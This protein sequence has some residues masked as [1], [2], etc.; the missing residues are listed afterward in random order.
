MAYLGFPKKVLPLPV[1]HKSVFNVINVTVDDLYL[2][3]IR[4]VVWYSQINGL[5]AKCGLKCT[6][7]FLS[8]NVLIAWAFCATIEWVCKY[9][10]TVIQK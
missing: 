5:R 1:V 6:A 9:N 10:G 2:F 3:V 7:F 8:L 4:W